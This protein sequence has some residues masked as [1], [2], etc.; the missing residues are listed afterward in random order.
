[1]SRVSLWVRMVLALHLNEWQ[2][3]FLSPYPPPWPKPSP[4]ATSLSAPERLCLSW[5]WEQVPLRLKTLT[6]PNWNW[7]ADPGAFHKSNICWVATI[8]WA[9]Y[10]AWRY[11]WKILCEAGNH[12]NGNQAGEQVAHPSAFLLS[13]ASYLHLLL[14]WM[15]IQFQDSLPGSDLIFLLFIALISDYWIYSWPGGGPFLNFL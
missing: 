6:E 10:L 9:L 4:S 1:M 2:L 12:M 11:R 5:L 8:C 14:L 7:V 3:S 13:M 15:A